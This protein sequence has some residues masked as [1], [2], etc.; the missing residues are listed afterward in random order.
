MAPAMPP[1]RWPRRRRPRPDPCPPAGTPGRPARW[2]SGDRAVA[3]DRALPRGRRH[4]A[5]RRPAPSPSAAAS[6]SMSSSGPASS[7]GRGGTGRRSSSWVPLSTTRP[8]SSTTMRSA[9]RSVE[10]RW[11]TRIVVRPAHDLAQRR[12]G[13]P[14]RCAASIDDVASSSSRT[15]G[16]VSSGPG[17]GDALALAAR[18]REAPLAHD[19]V[20]AVGQRG[21]ELVGPGRPGG[22][23][24]S[25]RRSR[26][27][28]RRRCS[29]RSCRRTGSSPRTP[30]RSGWRSES[31][32][33]VA[34]V[35]AV[36]A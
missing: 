22:R 16:S 24:E 27:A 19:G 34:D 10:R 25:A 20:V 14:P 8:P 23:H 33:T 6:V 3:V 5:R 29:R 15:W 35:D 21:D 9:R 11:A 17:Q 2:P 18:Q 28:G 36:D 31:S 1:P 26:R 4:R 13:S 7:A 12:R 32:V 30:P